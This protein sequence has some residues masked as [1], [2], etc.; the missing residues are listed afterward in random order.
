MRTDS[1]GRLRTILLEKKNR[2]RQSENLSCCLDE[3]GGEK[4][5]AVLLNLESDMWQTVT[6]RR[7]EFRERHRKPQTP[8]SPKVLGKHAWK[9][10]EGKKK[11]HFL[12]EFRQWED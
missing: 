12:E 9:G 8:G 5:K 2:S 10:I 1:S 7:R 11:L 6:G 3:D 4:A